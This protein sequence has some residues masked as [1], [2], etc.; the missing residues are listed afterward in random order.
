MGRTVGCLFPLE[1]FLVLSGTVNA[2]LQRR[3]ILCECNKM[4][5]MYELELWKEFSG[6]TCPLR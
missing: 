3:P 4:P 6:I 2:S 1:A 5:D